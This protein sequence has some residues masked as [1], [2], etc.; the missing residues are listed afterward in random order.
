MNDTFLIRNETEKDYDKVEEIT[1]QAFYNLYVPGCYEHYLVHVMRTHADFIPELALVAELDGR[2]IGSILYTKAWLMDAT[3]SKKEILTFG[4]VCIVPGYQRQ[5][6]GK[7]LM[8]YS[9][10]QAVALGYEAIVIFGDPANYVSRGFKSCKKFNVSLG[11]GTYPAAMMVKEL[12]TGALSDR[13][14]TYIQSAAL[15]ID[16]QA[17]ERFDAA[18]EKL[19]K[20]VLPCQ[21]HF[22]ILS[23]AVIQ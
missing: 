4:P 19:E 2:V 6:Y 17:A 23:H 3:G 1:R 22:Y 16:E 13:S 14:W 8:E 21:E 18:L 5:G 15:D 9:F 7:R 12:K 11:D 10:R 20:N